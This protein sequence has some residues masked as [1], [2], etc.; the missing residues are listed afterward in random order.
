M[1]P[2]MYY[3]WESAK[4]NGEMAMVL[5]SELRTSFCQELKQHGMSDQL[6]LG[7]ILSLNVKLESHYG[8][9]C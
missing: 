3:R 1:L 8:I 5:R 9:L 7:R 6:G 2:N 4:L